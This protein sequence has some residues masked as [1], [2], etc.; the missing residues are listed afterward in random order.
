LLENHRAHFKVSIRFLGL[1]ICCSGGA[2]IIPSQPPT[3]D[4]EGLH[5]VQRSE[6]QSRIIYSDSLQADPQTSSEATDEESQGG[7]HFLVVLVILFGFAAFAAG[8]IYWY[9]TRHFPIVVAINP[10]DA[11]PEV[12]DK[13]ATGKPGALIPVSPDMLHVTSIALGNS[14]LTIVNGKRLAK[15]DWLVLKTPQGEASVRVISIQDGFV[16]FKHGGETMDVPL[17]VV[18]APTPH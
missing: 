18:K 6:P 16:R 3:P 4:D 13:D 14:P 1:Q 10:P 5:V 9:Q 7:R 8:G 12:R 15:E 2:S 17:Q 11:A